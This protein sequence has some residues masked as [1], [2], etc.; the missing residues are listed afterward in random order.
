MSPRRAGRQIEISAARKSIAG[1]FMRASEV[2]EFLAIGRKKLWELASAGELER[3]GTRSATRYTSK[4][5]E[6]YAIRRR[7]TG[8]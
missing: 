4:S 2:R 3:V 1:G 7:I 8:R 5:V 6:Q